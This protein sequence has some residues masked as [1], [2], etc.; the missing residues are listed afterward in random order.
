MNLTHGKG[1]KCPCPIYYVP[2]NE[3]Q[4]LDKTHELCMIKK[5]QAT[6]DMAIAAPMFKAC[7]AILKPKGIRII[8]Q[9][10]L[11]C[12]LVS[13]TQ[14]EFQNAFWSVQFS[15][16]HTATGFDHMHNNAYG[17]GGKHILPELKCHIEDIGG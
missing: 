1:G 11:L 2:R 5:T 10:V 3:Q 4:E 13:C 7:E 12:G 9:C 15:D 17:T 6:Y 14:Y 16:P 8:E